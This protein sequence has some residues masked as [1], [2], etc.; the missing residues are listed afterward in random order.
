MANTQ[1]TFTAISQ[2]D[3]EKAVLEFLKADYGHKIGYLT[4]HFGRVWQRFNFFI[5]LESGFSAAMWVWFKE[6]GGW[7]KGAF[8]LAVI[9]A[10]SSLCWYVFGAQDRY[11]IAAYREHIKDCGGRLA[12][13]LGLSN[14][15]HVGSTE[16]DLSEHHWYDYVTQW[17]S[18]AF[19]TTRLAVWFPLLVVGYW[20]VVIVLI[21]SKQG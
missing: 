5:T 8:A 21:V 18:E 12:D 10:V 13:S 16:A 6:K 7:N 19:S 4:N 11:L 3:K 2:E 14:H 9:G 15:I 17:R 20:I 1:V